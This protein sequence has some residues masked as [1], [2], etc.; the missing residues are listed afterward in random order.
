M[1]TQGTDG[2]SRGNLK[3]GVGSGVDMLSIVP[4]HLSALERHPKCES[5]LRSWIGPKM[6]ILWPAEWYPRSHDIEG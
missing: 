4:L 5:W 1:I 2:V 3:E 6:E